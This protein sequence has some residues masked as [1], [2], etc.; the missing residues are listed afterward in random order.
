MR[1]TCEPCWPSTPGTTTAD[2]HT[3][4]T[5]SALP[6]QTT[7]LGTASTNGSDDDRSWEA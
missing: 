4:V 6:R 1:D 7:P 3:E 2:D 5:N